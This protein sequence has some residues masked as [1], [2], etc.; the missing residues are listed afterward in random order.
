MFPTVADV[1]AMPVVR[2]GAPTVLVGGAA[3]AREVRWVH[4]AEIADIAHLLRGGELVLTTGIA[5]PDDPRGLTSY[6]Q[7]LGT[8]GAVGLVVEL[9]RRWTDGLPAALVDACEQEALPLVALGREVRYAAV[10]QAVGERIVDAQ[11]AELRAA[12]QVHDSFTRLSVAGAAPAEILAEVARF[13]G[14][15]VVLESFRHQVL[16]YHAGPMAAADL[17]DGWERRSAAV[18]PG[19]RTAY[20]RREGWLVTVVGARGDDWGR[21]VLPTPEP[22]PHRHVVLVERAAAALALHRL[23]ARERDSVER[24]TH[25]ALLAALDVAD[26]GEDVVT[27]SGVAGVP[28]PGRRL[29]GLALRP[30]L[31]GGSPTSTS[32]QSLGELAATAAAATRACEVPALVAVVDDEVRMLLSLPPRRE[33]DPAVDRVAREVHRQAGGTAV[34][35]GAGGPVD[36]PGAAHRTLG[37][38]RHVVAAARPGPDDARL[39]HRLQDVHVRG[40]LHLLGNDDRLR[41]FVEREI[42]VLLRHDTASGGRSRD[43]LLDAVRALLDHPGNKAAAAAALHVSRP[44]FYE[45]LAKTERL[46]GVD[47]ADPEVRTSLH[48]AL[49]A[50]DGAGRA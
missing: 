43:R 18:R 34:L 25:G 30:H 45:R 39:V 48:L 11:L 28:L 10:A 49:L 27:R 40:L 23:H 16:G 5:L 15:P 14:L 29:V 42:G 22:P 19:E 20:D 1:L 6:V 9:G 41:L 46:L 17:L 24:Q 8:V 33:P 12:E 37:E 4:S 50:H 3:L 7:A 26:V 2:Q 47:L 13:S 21:L 35:V 44:V 31:G 38:A 36:S 32:E